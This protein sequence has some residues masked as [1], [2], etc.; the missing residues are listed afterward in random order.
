MVKDIRINE[1]EFFNFINMVKE[2]ISNGDNEDN[3]EK[4]KP[5]LN[6]IDYHIDMR[7]IMNEKDLWFSFFK[8]NN[9]PEAL[10]RYKVLKDKYNTLKAINIWRYNG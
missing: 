5:I 9:S 7:N 3:E 2:Y 1:E 6:F 4:K 10:E 8:K